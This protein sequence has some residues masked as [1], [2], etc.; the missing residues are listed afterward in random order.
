MRRPSRPRWTPDTAAVVVQSPNHFGIV[1]DLAALAPRVKAAGAL[2]LVHVEPTSLGVLEPP[3]AFGADVVTGEGQS[4]GLPLSFGGPYL[5]IIGVSREL[6]RRLPGRLVGRTVD[7][8]GRPGFVLTLQTREQHIRREKATSNICTNQGLMALAATVYLAALGEAGLRSLAE[9]LADRAGDLA[10]RIERLRRLPAA[11]RGRHLP[12]VR[13]PGAAG[14]AV[15]LAAPRARARGIAAG[16]PLG[17]DFPALGP[18]EPAGDGLGEARPGRAG[19][20]RGLPQGGGGMSQT[21]FD[22]S[23]PGRPGF[24]P[25]RGRARPAAPRL[26]AAKRRRA[27]L[28][29]PALSELEVLRHYVG[30]SLLNHSIA[31]GFYPLGSCT[32]KYN[33]VQNEQL[34]A[35]PGFAGCHPAQDAGDRARAAS[36]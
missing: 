5:G 32:M 31:R 6:V 10:A 8:Q 27:P 28:G 33:P 3:G 26:A 2:L 11:L 16:L 13:R 30:L 19:P 29:L 21:I 18:N 23:R 20:L 34:A 17:D 1:E 25:A 35:L 9:G 7:A 12:G 14:R 15:E 24:R 4:L 36:S 22:K